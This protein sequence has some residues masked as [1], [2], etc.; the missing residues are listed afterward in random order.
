MSLFRI[1]GIVLLVVG[2]VVLVLGVY[3]LVTYN[4]STVGKVSNW[5]ARQAGTRTERV[6]NSI[7]QIVIGAACAGVGFFLYRKS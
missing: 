7:I 6:R 1:I 3:N 4:K 2:V 5:F